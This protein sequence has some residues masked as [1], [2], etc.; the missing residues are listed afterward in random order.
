M[1]KYFRLL[2]SVFKRDDAFSDSVP[3]FLNHMSVELRFEGILVV[4]VQLL[5]AHDL[6]LQK[7]LQHILVGVVGAFSQEQPVRSHLNIVIN[8]ERCHFFAYLGFLILYSH[9]VDAQNRFVLFES[10][11]N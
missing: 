9:S 10:S 8:E 2:R 1:A 4:F 3:H 7:S 11:E 5:L 6:L